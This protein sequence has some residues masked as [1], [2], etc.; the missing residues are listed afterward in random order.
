M[1]QEFIA[2]HA[3]EIVDRTRRRLEGRNYP[4]PSVREV[5]FG[6][7]LFLSQLGETLRLEA[8]PAP[9]ATGTIGAT[10][11]RHGAELFE[12]GFTVSQVVPI[13]ATSARRLRNL[14]L[15]GTLE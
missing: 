4:P 15:S 3:N 5:E 11:A 14:P 10:A 8:T 9:F 1:L 13:T 7:P 6:V 2:A 12:A